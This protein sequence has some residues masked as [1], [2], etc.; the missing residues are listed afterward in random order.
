LAFYFASCTKKVDLLPAK[1]VNQKSLASKFKSRFY[2]YKQN[3][4]KNANASR[5]A[6]EQ[7]V[8]RTIAL[9]WDS[10]EVQNASFL[11]IEQEVAVIP[12]RYKNKDMVING[13][14]KLI[15][16]KDQ[17]G[18]EQIKVLEVTAS[19]EYLQNNNQLIKKHNLTGSL[20]IHDLYN[21]F[22]GGVVLENG[23]IINS[24]TN[25][26]NTNPS[27]QRSGN[28]GNWQFIAHNCSTRSSCGDEHETG[29]HWVFIPCSSNINDYGYANGSYYDW[30]LWLNNQYANDYA[31]NNPPYWDN[32]YNDPNQNN[33][34]GYDIV[35]LDEPLEPDWSNDE[36]DGVNAPTP[37]NFNDPEKIYTKLRNEINDQISLFQAR[38][39]NDSLGGGL[40]PTQKSV[41]R[42]IFLPELKQMKSELKALARSNQKYKIVR[43]NAP[44]I[45]LDVVT[46]EIVISI[47]NK[48]IKTVLSTNIEN[49]DWYAIAHEFKHAF[50]FEEGKLSFNLHSGGA[51]ALYD[52]QDEIEAY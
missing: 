40:T 10:L 13:Y 42:E 23:N 38:L 6:I 2:T 44:N 15:I 14:R 28:C 7:T 43:S 26:T 21:G 51:G 47:P 5:T 52:L 32:S 18:N 22:E 20:T 48:I 35:N 37:S 31:Q 45:S 16:F 49:E 30:L 3:I 25:Y 29:G 9:Q 27:T 17:A 39:N 12:L 19:P 50:Q 1:Q 8:S 33:N 46:K 4:Q 34:G 36:F 24:I 41:L 11:G